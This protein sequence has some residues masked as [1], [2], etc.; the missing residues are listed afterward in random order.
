MI[1]CVKEKLNWGFLPIHLRALAID[2]FRALS[3]FLPPPVSRY[4]GRS[5]VNI[6]VSYG[7]TLTCP[8]AVHVAGTAPTNLVSETVILSRLSDNLS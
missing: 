5:A 2:Y 1:S 4:L 6:C 7:R 8:V 3:E